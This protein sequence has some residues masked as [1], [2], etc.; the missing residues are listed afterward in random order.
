VRKNFEI[1]NGILKATQR[2]LA[3]TPENNLLP[4]G[5]A[6]EEKISLDFLVSINYNIY[7]HKKQ[8][9]I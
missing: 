8:A 5:Q 3:L 4:L 6:R 9:A 2:K 7:V 1:V